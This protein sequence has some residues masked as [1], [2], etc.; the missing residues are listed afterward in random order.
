MA[1]ERKKRTVMEGYNQYGSFNAYKAHAKTAAR[2]LCYG[3]DVVR[4]INNAKTEEEISRI[5]QRAR[6][7]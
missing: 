1:E 7:R 6:V 2:D 5:M 4:Q 3:D